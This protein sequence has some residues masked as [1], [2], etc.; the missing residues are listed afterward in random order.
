MIHFR[1][2]TL[3][4]GARK[5]IEDANLQ[6]HAGWRVGLVG[7]NGSGKS[8]LFALL[9]GELHSELGDCEVPAA[10][11]IATVAQETPALDQ[12]AIDYVL[13]GDT[14]LREIEREIAAAEAH[15]E[16]G[17]LL[18]ELHGRLNDIGG[19]GAHSRAAAL[20]AGLGFASEDIGRSVSEFSGGWRMR[21]NLA[22]ALVSRCDLMLLDEPTN[23]LDLDA[24]VWLEKWLASFRGTLVVVSHD[25]DFLDGCT[26]NIA[27]IYNERLTLYTG[28]YTAFET[29]RAATLA[30]QQSMFEKQQRQIE[31]L[32]KYIARFRAQATKARQAQSRLKALD[33]MEV[34]SAAHVDTPFD[35]SFMEPA[36]APDPMLTL[37]DV[38]AGYD[39]VPIISGVKLSLRPGAR[40]GL[41]GPNGAGKSTLVKLL[42][43]ES[44][45][46]AGR[47]VEGR[48][49]AIGYFAQH[50]LEQLR[51]DESPLKHMTRSEPSTRE[52]E[53]RNFLGGFDFRGNMVDTL[54]GPFSGGEKSRLALALMIRTRPNLL[55]L[56]EPTNH[57]DLEMRQALTM[58]LSEYEGSLVLVSHDRTLLRTVCDSFLLVADGKV[59]EFDGDVDDYLAWLTARRQALNRPVAAAPA[60]KTEKLARREARVN[61]QQQQGS[62]RTLEKEVAKLDRDLAKWN[63]EK[64]ELDTRLADPALYQN[65]STADLRKLAARQTELA[66]FIDTDEQRWL[67]TQAELETMGAVQ[68]V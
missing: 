36:R 32:E 6:I 45:L 54:V 47:R 30:V 26:T 64:R 3:A 42:S 23:H 25:R 66:K 61:P 28:N 2:F 67:E 7:A 17:D 4:R 9:R 41:L 31:H 10:W 57:L 29:Q 59:Q 13:D 24:V 39:G 18:G 60:V 21:L 38:D 68:K 63:T 52:Q 16:G 35:F 22:Q 53:L 5:L 33:R 40:I 55:L 37:E 43:G 8:S 14:E 11:R 1:N 49:L 12:S 51:P 20:L 34:I 46:L 15:H 62:R 48:G 56:D 65:T 44:A 58:A 50:Q 19:Y 27:H